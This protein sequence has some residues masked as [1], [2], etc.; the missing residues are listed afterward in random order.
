MFPT[1]KSQSLPLYPSQ[2]HPEYKK[3][4]K[5]KKEKDCCKLAS[6]FSLKNIK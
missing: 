1:L 5:Y 4:L 3:T 6:R 2:G